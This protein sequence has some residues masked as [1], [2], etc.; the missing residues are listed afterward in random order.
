M[1]D[2]FFWTVS[3]TG[4]RI[5]MDNN[6]AFNYT[7]D[8]QAVFLG[9]GVYSIFDTSVKD[10]LISTLWFE[11]MMDHLFDSIG[12]RYSVDQGNLVSTCKANYPDIYMDFEGQ[13][14]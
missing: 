4:F 11:P 5:G 1:Q 8:P 7:Y 12:Q 14:L 13:M 2:D 10:M 6:R 3:N 9:E